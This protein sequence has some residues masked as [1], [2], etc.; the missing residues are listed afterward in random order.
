MA[1]AKKVPVEEFNVELTLSKK[2]VEVIFNLVGSVVGGGDTR[3]ITND[4]YHSLKGIVS[5]KKCFKTLIE[6]I[7]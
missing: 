4:I 3:T 7:E 6:T 5:Y 2:E 1:T